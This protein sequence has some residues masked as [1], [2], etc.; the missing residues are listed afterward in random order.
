MARIVIERENGKG[1]CNKRRKKGE[2]E[3][4][5]GDKDDNL[6]EVARG[7]IDPE[8]HH[9]SQSPQLPP[10]PSHGHLLNGL[11][12]LLSHWLLFFH[13]EQPERTFENVEPN[14]YVLRAFQ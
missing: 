8:S 9:F 14:H 3:E 4:R 7:Q 1:V 6:E 10:H 2:G 11:L 12:P 5:Q 13:P